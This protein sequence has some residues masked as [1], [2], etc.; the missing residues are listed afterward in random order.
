MFFQTLTAVLSHPEKFCFQFAK[1][2]LLLPTE[3]QEKFVYHLQGNRE[4]LNI[5]GDKHLKLI[6]LIGV[7]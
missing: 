7:G 1:N 6:H 4:I 5:G 2:D 3:N